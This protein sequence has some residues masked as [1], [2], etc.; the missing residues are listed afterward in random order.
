[1]VFFVKRGDL[2][3]LLQMLW[4]APQGYKFRWALS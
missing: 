4:P 3:P 2:Y 1:M